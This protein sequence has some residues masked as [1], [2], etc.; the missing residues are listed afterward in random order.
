MTRFTLIGGTKNWS[1]WTLRPW[2]LMKVAQIPFDEIEITLRDGDTTRAEIR[3]QSPS[4]LIPVLKCDDGLTLWDSLAI[5]EYLAERFPERQLWPHDP[6][7]RAMARV[8]ACEMHAGFTAM[9]REMAMDCV[10]SLPRPELSADAS[11]D[12]A[13]IQQIW[14]DMRNEFGAGGPFLF[15]TFSIA[16]AMY[17]PVVSRFA[18]YS[19]PMETAERAYTGAISTLP[20]MQEW[21]AA[22]AAWA[23][24]RAVQ[25]QA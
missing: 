10:A 5:A 24:R 4:G 2:L 3:A 25:S 18:T 8:A 20:A 1:S 14:R 22:C 15:G 19:I 7:A 12:V 9:R 21:M 6:R 17:A 23:A 11:R 13:R 16:D